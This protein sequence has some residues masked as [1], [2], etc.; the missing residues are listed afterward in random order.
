M[1]IWSCKQLQH[2]ALAEVCTLS[3]MHGT[4]RMTAELV[5]LRFELGT[6]RQFVSCGTRKHGRHLT[7]GLNGS[8]LTHVLQSQCRL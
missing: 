2:A 7:K 1:R 4:C 8:L 3:S 6:Q 5:V